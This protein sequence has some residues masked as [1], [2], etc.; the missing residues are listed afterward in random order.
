MQNW[1][2]KCKQKRKNH[3]DCFCNASNM[4]YSFIV[5]RYATDW[6]VEKKLQQQLFIAAKLIYILR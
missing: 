3:F 5:F 6:K 1:V 2:S 4:S